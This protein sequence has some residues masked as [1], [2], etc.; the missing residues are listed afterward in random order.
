MSRVEWYSE[1]P[2]GVARHALAGFG[3]MVLCIGGF[4]WWAFQAPLAAAVISAGSFVATGQNQIV[5]HLEGGIIQSFEVREGDEVKAGQIL[6]R[7]D[8]TAARATRRELYLRS[9]RLQAIQARLLASASEAG[10]LVYPAA[11][12]GLDDDPE[13]AASLQAQFPAFLAQKTSLSNDIGQ[14]ERN[15]EALLARRRGYTRQIESYSQI[16]SIFAAELK[17][18][19]ALFTR[20]LTARDTVTVLQR[21]ALDASGQLGRLEAEIEEID[22]M[23]EKYATQIDAVRDKYREATLT[24]LQSVEAE[25]ESVRENIRKAEKVLE[26]TELRAPVTGTVVRLHYHTPGGVIEPGRVIAELLP[27]D[28]PLIAESYVQRNDIDAVRAGQ[29]AAVRLVGLNQRTTPILEGRVDYVSADAVSQT[30]GS[31]SREVYVVRVSLDPRELAR[32]PHVTLKSGMPVEIMIRTEER[33]FAQYII[34]PVLDSM[35]RAF[36]EQ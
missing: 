7:L 6:L 5:Q 32:L 9:I 25:L 12:T 26:R 21:A 24:E 2:F 20:G 34:R 13:I 33:S 10:E 4:G 31:T 11:L 18:K 3:L 14:V 19:E 28:A 15:I 17:D 35:N 22:R 27:A 30:A 29:P 23:N 16:S 8:E 1:V 36:R